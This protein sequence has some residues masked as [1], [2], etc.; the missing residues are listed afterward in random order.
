[1][2]ILCVTRP[3]FH[4][5]HLSISDDHR[6]INTALQTGNAGWRRV[7]GTFYCWE[8][9]ILG[10]DPK[11][12]NDKNAIR[13]TNATLQKR[14]RGGD[15]GVFCWGEGPYVFLQGR[16]GTEFEVTSLNDQV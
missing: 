15:H 3:N 13:T 16:G 12:T 5:S 11:Y 14:R 2:Y 4:K 7:K 10:L 1:V 6:G 9:E 8:K